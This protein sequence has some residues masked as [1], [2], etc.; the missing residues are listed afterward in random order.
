MEKELESKIFL[1]ND[2]NTKETM[3]EHIKEYIRQLKIAY[4]TAVITREFYKGNNILI[5]ATK[6]FDNRNVNQE[7]NKKELS[8]E[9]DWYIRQKGER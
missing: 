1:V 2:Y 6:I 5:R 8:R 3:E 4:P 9:D 7:K